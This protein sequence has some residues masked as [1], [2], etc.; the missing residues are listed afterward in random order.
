MIVVFHFN[1]Y[2]HFL[3]ALLIRNAYLFVDFFFVLSGFIILRTYGERLQ[4]GFGLAR[5]MALRFG[6]LY[7]L[8]LFM[9][10]LFLI[11]ECAWA[12]F[13][14]DFSSDPRP[15][16][17]GAFSMESLFSNL[18]LLNAVGLHDGLTWN[19]PSWSIG[20]E[21]FTYALFA[22]AVVLCGRLA[23]ASFLVL[24]IVGFVTMMWTLPETIGVPG[25]NGIF[26]CMYGFSIGALLS[27]GYRDWKKYSW[28]HR[29]T[30]TII[31]IAT[32]IVCLAF[33]IGA[34][35]NR[36]SLAAPFF[37]AG[38]V[39]V[40]AQ[41][42]GLV[43]ALLNGRPFAWLGTLSY[44]IYMVHAFIIVLFTNAVTLAEKLTGFSL[45]TTIILAGE[46]RDAIGTSLLAGDLTYVAL[47]LCVMFSASLSYHYVE[48]PTRNLSRKIAARMATP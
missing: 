18:L 8:H 5:F 27:F 9:I 7:P 39:I 42:G 43:S 28:F 24:G 46:S 35:D 13:L 44:S 10:V 31:E 23:W 30:A 38:V 1:P 6:R 48:A 11:Y 34:G 19:Y 32:V 25:A 20:A 47:F 33:V 15:A 12:A 29:T 14:H 16:F 45:F 2:S 17:E 37:F 41:E 21:F 22:M 26:R 36:L 3:E 40:Y 4:K